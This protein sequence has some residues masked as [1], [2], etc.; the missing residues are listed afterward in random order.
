M[1][2]ISN[3]FQ[4]HLISHIQR[5]FLFGTLWCYWSIYWWYTIQND[6][7]QKQLLY[8]MILKRSY[9]L[10]KTI[11]SNNPFELPTLVC[12]Y[13]HIRIKCQLSIEFLHLFSFSTVTGWKY[14]HHKMRNGY[15]YY[16]LAKINVELGRFFMSLAYSNEVSAVIFIYSFKHFI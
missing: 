11:R 7:S 13:S 9:K 10:V 5:N 14:L 8:P 4:F 3:A 12:F 6:K 16:Q 2:I 1:Q 15:Y